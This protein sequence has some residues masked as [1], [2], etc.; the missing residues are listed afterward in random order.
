MNPPH[1]NQFARVEFAR[2]SSI[3][4][5]P[6]HPWHWVITIQ[7]G[8]VYMIS[9]SFTTLA[10]CVDDF[11]ANG[12]EEVAKIE[13]ELRELY[14]GADLDAVNFDGQGTAPRDADGSSPTA[15]VTP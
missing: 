10:E 8:H 11:R 6:R 9:D 2:G 14:G 5:G 3:A 7:L 15:G 12:L 13:A 1:S 4:P